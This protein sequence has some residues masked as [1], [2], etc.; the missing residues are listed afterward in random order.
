MSAESLEIAIKSVLQEGKLTSKVVIAVDL[1]G[2]PADFPAKPLGCYGD[3]G[4]IF[5]NNDGGAEL[6]KI[7]YSAGSEELESP[8][9]TVSCKATEKI[10]DT[11]LSL[12]MHAY[13]QKRDIEKIC[14]N[15]KTVC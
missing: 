3:G 6:I 2:Q 10:C 14:S 15:V 7:R 9:D 4:A 11:C 8:G 12:P 13:L 5:T 1:F